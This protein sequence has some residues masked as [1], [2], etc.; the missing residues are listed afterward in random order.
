MVTEINRIIHEPARLEVLVT[1]FS[2]EKADFTF[3]KNQTGMTQG[4]L[5]SHL[6]K[7]EK[8]GYIQSEKTFRHKR[9]QTLLLITELG[10]SA[11]RDY[12]NF[13]YSWYSDLVSLLK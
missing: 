4:N 13:M 6:I 7:L 1:L 3:L 9:P 5:S 2:V 11:V 10:R 12:V 8:A